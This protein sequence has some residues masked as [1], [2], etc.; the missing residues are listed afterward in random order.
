MS[1][2]PTWKVG[3]VVYRFIDSIERMG[4]YQYTVIKVHKLKSEL[5]SRTTRVMVYHE[6]FAH[7][8]SASEAGAVQLAIKATQQEASFHLSVAGS[9]Q[10]LANTYK[11]FL[12]EMKK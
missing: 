3:D 8:Y 6:T 5:R 10:L 1:V 7:T 2:T 12:L 11:K 9:K 4:V